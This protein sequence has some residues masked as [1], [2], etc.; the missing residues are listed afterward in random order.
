LAA[1]LT[2]EKAPSPL[3]HAIIEENRGDFG[4]FA[5]WRT[6][7]HAGLGQFDRHAQVNF[8]QD[9]VEPVVA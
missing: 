1:R 7:G 5:G 3:R 9:L 2:R 8:G 4:N 6:S